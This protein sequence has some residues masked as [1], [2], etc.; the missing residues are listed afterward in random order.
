MTEWANPRTCEYIASFG[1]DPRRVRLRGTTRDG[2]SEF[3]FDEHD[4]RVWDE[5]QGHF[6]ATEKDW[7]EG[8]DF[9][10]LVAAWLEDGHWYIGG[11]MVHHTWTGKVNA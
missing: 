8:F 11:E 5:E 7:P 10:H 4:K 2:Y 9:N 6:L 1:L 3:V